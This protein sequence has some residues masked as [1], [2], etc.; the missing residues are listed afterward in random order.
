[1]D[2]VRRT[3]SPTMHPGNNYTLNAAM[4]DGFLFVTSLSDISCVPSDMTVFALPN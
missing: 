1:M 2:A 4:A 3:N